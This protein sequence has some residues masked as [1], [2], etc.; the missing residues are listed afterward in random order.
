M[1]KVKFKD[2]SGW[3][4]VVAIVGFIDLAVWAIYFVD[5]VLTGLAY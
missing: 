2:L 5:G 4:K 1:A 3:L